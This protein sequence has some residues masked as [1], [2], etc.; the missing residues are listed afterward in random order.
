[1]SKIV[2]KIR[3]RNKSKKEKSGESQMGKNRKKGKGV[4]VRSVIRS[5]DR[6]R[7]RQVFCAGIC[8]GNIL[9]CH[10]D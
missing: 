7:N 4:S 3:E 1:M 2:R 5:D 10:Q 9:P 6:E 8:N